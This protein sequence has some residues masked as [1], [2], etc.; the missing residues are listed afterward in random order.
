MPFRGYASFASY[1]RARSRTPLFAAVLMACA[2]VVLSY[3]RASAQMSSSAQ[4]G[5]TPAASAKATMAAAA[6][7]DVATWIKGLRSPSAAVRDQSVSSLLK[8]GPAALPEILPRLGEQRTRVPLLRIVADM[9][10]RGTAKLVRLTDDPAL[11]PV[12]AEALGYTARPDAAAQIPGL[13]GC[14]SK[15]AE[16]RDSCGRALVRVAGPAAAPSVDALRKSARAGDPLTKTYVL[17]ALSRIGRAAG[18][19]MPEALAG[20]RDATASVRAASGRALGA[21]G[22]ATPEVYAALNASAADSD[23]D[24]R[25][26]AK[27]AL[28]S[29]PK[30][31]PAAGA[32]R[33]PAVKG[34]K[35]R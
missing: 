30:A 6:E 18:R 12:A 24:V 33:A 14:M 10:P 34:A 19:A 32:H 1:T 17:L 31:A 8:A 26:A 27:N 35:T 11:G 20:M 29:L 23:A 21:F 2:A 7:G 13:L 28:K 22:R 4:S 3:T 16:L 15:H 25:L 9:G 5:Q